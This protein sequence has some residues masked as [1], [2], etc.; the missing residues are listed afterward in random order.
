MTQDAKDTKSMIEQLVHQLESEDEG[1]RCAAREELVDVG[2][3]DVTRALVFELND[4]RR[5][6]RFEAAKAL[7]SIADPIAAPAL[8]QHLSDD[9][10]DIRWLAAEGLWRFGEAGLLTTLN[11]SIRNASNAE[12]SDAA[13][14]A[15]KEFRKQGVRAK[16]LDPVI[17]ACESSE[18]GVSLRLAAYKAVE[19]IKTGKVE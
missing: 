8:V 12:F 11:E 18:P 16:Y 19:Q 10:Y 4:P 9:D 6:V 14:H 2:G 17:K 13:H 1:E 3:H 7:I 5:N 15:F